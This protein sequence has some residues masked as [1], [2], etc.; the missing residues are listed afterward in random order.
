MT[1]DAL[2][3]R[4][5]VGPTPAGRS[6]SPGRSTTSSTN[7]AESPRL[8]TRCRAATSYS[9]WGY[10]PQPT[11]AQLAR[12]P[13]DYPAQIAVDGAYLRGRHRATSV[14][15]FGSPDH[16]VWADL[17]LREQ[18]RRLGA[19][20]RS[21]SPPEDVAG[22]AQNPYAA[23]VALEAWFRSAGGFVYDEQPPQVATACR[24][25]SPS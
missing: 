8:L 2:H 13:A 11:P 14:P 12:S 23:T 4:H 17:L 25:S 20:G 19:T 24:R 3:D 16:D 18:P 15:P 7:A 10:K 5:L 9:V 22:K 6:T 21:T 1:I